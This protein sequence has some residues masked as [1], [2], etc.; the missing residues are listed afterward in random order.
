VVLSFRHLDAVV[1][2]NRSDG[3]IA[4]KLGGTATP[5]SLGVIGDP[6]FEPGGAGGFGGQHDAR[7]LSDG[8]LTIF[9]NGSGRARPPRGVRYHLDLAQRTATFVHE[10]ADAGAPASFCCGSYRQLPSGNHVLGWGGNP[11]DTADFVEIESS[12]ERV[13]ELSF[14]DP[15]ALA[16]R[17]SPVAV[18]GKL[19]RDVLRAG[20]DAQYP[21]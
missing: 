1:K 13:F 2:V 7:L 15:Q 18:A 14:T 3:S 20:M 4:W 8:T 21:G 11:D 9:D 10:V 16:Y 19:H 5:E 6:A 17:A 12:G